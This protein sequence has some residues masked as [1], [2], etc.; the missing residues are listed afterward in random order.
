[1]PDRDAGQDSYGKDM[2]TVAITIL[3]MG[4]SI[5]IVIVMYLTFGHIGPSFSS[6]VMSTQQASLRKQY[7]LPSCNQ[8]PKDMLETPPSLRNVTNPCQK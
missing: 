6:S 7:D 4:V 2:K 1:M 5:A 3:V 8:V